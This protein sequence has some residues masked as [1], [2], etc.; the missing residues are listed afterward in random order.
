MSTISCTDNGIAAAL[1]DGGTVVLRPLERGET[2]PQIAVLDKMSVASRWQR[3]LTAVPTRLPT[4]VL[5]ALSDIDGRRHV[6]WLASVDGRPAG[7]ARYVECEPGLAEVAFEVVDAH[8]GRGIGS[9]LLEAVATVAA[10]KRGRATLCDGGSQQ[11]GIG[12]AAPTR[13]AD[14]AACRRA[15][16][17]RVPH[18]PARDSPRRPGA[19]GRSGATP[20]RARPRPGRPRGGWGSPSPV[21]TAPFGMV[22]AATLPTHEE[23]SVLRQR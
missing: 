14:V 13:R 12:A 20:V 9:L 11:P 16:R 6:A 17:R 22:T 10:T 21:R 4:A 5:A 7:V 2:A 23:R 19:G 3:F 15:A 8:H 18:R 1:R